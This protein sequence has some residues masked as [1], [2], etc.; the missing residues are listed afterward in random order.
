MYPEPFQSPKDNNTQTQANS[1]TFQYPQAYN[2]QTQQNTSQFQQSSFGELYP[3]THMPPPPPPS[4]KHKFFKILIG[5]VVASG[6]VASGAIVGVFASHQ[7]SKTPIQT[8]ATLQPTP[9]KTQAVS[10]PTPTQDIAIALGTS[11]FQTFLKAFAIAMA[12][13]DYADIQKATDTQNFQYIPLHA[14]GIGSWGDTYNELTTGNLSAV[15][16]YPLITPSQE[17]FCKYTQNG[18]PGLSVNATSIE[19]DVGTLSGNA[20]DDTTQTNRNGTVFAF[21]SVTGSNWL[22]RALITNNDIC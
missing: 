18:L 12:S 16:Q 19:Y 10:H 6:L 1:G 8:Q 17:G 13:K 7:F 5:I 9:T 21:E 15:L 20:V 14:D 22:W 3:Y 4:N 11:D 2:A